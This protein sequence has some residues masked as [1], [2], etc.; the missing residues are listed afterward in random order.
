VP[1]LTNLTAL[2]YLTLSSSPIT[3]LPNLTGLTTLEGFYLYVIPITTPP[4]LT[5]LTAL[6]ELVLSNT[7]IT[8]PPDLTGLIVLQYL[9]LTSNVGFDTSDIDAVLGYFSV[10]RESFNYVYINNIALPTPSVLLTAQTANP[11]C[12]FY[13]NN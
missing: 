8:T 1:D 7:S 3:T 5:G 10:L 11:Q 9:D 4:N 12:T 13:V 6:R 2:R